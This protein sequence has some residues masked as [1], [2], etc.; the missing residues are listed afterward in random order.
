[1]KRQNAQHQVINSIDIKSV[2]E[3]SSKVQQLDV[4]V[5]VYLKI[6]IQK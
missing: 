6:A 1:M 2:D 3:Y 5:V 4:K